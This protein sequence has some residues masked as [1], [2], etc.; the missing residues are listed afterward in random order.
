MI[1]LHHAYHSK[2]ESERGS[3]P[4]YSE[5]EIERLLLEGWNYMKDRSECL[6]ELAKF[7]RMKGNYTKAYVYAKLGVDIPYPQNRVLFVY[8]DVY[9]WRLKDE[10]AICSYYLGKYDESIKYCQKIMRFTFDERI[11]SNM[12]FSVNEILKRVLIGCQ[13][14]ISFSKN[15]LTGL[16]MIVHYTESLD[17]V[18]ILMN[19]LFY[20]AK[21]IY[22]FER[23]LLVVE[24][25][26]VKQVEEIKSIYPIFEFV[27]WKH[28]SHILP[29][30]KEKLNRHDRF[31]FETDDSWIAIAKKN[32]F[33]RALSMLNMDKNYGQLI[34]NRVNANSIDQYADKVVGTVVQDPETNDPEQRIYYMNEKFKLASPAPSIYKR[35]FFDSITSYDK[36][37]DENHLITLFQNQIDFVR[38][39]KQITV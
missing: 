12:K 2:P 19:S 26:K 13:R 3:D 25:S 32:Y 22:L 23:F 30:I 33:T 27:T 9:T 16:T 34:Y 28:P 24:E 20:H 29:N 39:K 14:T 7:F 11:L 6:C 8:K 31:I 38:I 15:R 10:V 35:E 37:I 17:F 4:Y 1:A 21:D 36:P 18:K 5:E